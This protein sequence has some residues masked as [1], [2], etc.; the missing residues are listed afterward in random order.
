MTS[1]EL[2]VKRWII[3]VI[4]SFIFAFLHVAIML[5]MM[6]MNGWVILS[7]I[8]GYTMGFALFNHDSKKENCPCDSEIKWS[9]INHYSQL[10][11]I[12]FIICHINFEWYIKFK[13]ILSISKSLPL[14]MWLHLA[15][16]IQSKSVLLNDCLIFSDF[17]EF[18]L[19][20]SI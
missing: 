2:L 20:L 6:S 5:V 10:I 19:R 17:K 12:I 1:Q 11:L 4:Y 7:V 15:G 18:D 3:P 13:L 9:I 14:Q 16:S 8:V